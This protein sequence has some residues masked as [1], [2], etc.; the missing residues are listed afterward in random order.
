MDHG[1]FKHS[2]KET[3]SL[4]SFHN[5]GKV[6]WCS[7]IPAPIPTSYVT[8]MIRIFL[9]SVSI[10]S[11]F[12]KS[13]EEPENIHLDPKPLVSKSTFI[14]CDTDTL[15]IAKQINESAEWL[16]LI[17]KPLVTDDVDLLDSLIPAIEQ[18]AKHLCFAEGERSV[19]SFHFWQDIHKYLTSAHPWNEHPRFV[20]CRNAIFKLTRSYQ[21]ALISPSSEPYLGQT[22]PS[23]NSMGVFQKL[24]SETYRYKRLS[25]LVISPQRT[26]AY[27][28]SDFSKEPES[29]LWYYNNFV[30][31]G[32]G[33][34]K[35]FFSEKSGD[36]TLRLWYSSNEW[37]MVAQLLPRKDVHC[38]SSQ[39]IYNIGFDTIRDYVNKG[40]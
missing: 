29:I 27:K 31:M 35:K 5:T 37:V 36:G 18:V 12:S 7:S 15:F 16:G 39:L 38:D 21:Q 4:V 40:I 28:Q 25:L 13:T 14:K 26:I 11:A 17:G 24:L 9:V 23:S 1:D 3:F 22:S 2:S 34:L 8:E 20:K 19:G 30:N 6:Y 10:S 33:W 32:G